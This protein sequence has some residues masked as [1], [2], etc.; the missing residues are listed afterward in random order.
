MAEGTTRSAVTAGT[1]SAR[2]T[3]EIETR[4]RVEFRDIT[5]AIERLVAQTGVSSGVCYVFTPHTT[6]AILVNE[7]ADPA[8]HQDFDAF[9]KKLAPRDSAYHHND[10]NCDAHL[11]AAIIGP[12]K[13]LLIESGSLLL[14]R[15][16][17]VFLCEFDGPRRRDIH[18]KVVSD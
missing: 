17:G 11:K 4:A 6:A 10:G 12:S 8:L 14:G 18:V 3:L 5:D 15:W 7:N 16:Q 1:R 9:L 2:H 13:S